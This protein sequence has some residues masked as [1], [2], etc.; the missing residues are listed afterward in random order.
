MA[1]E[2][3]KGFAQT[4]WFRSYFDS[5]AQNG[6]AGAMFWILTPDPQ[7][8]YGVTHVNWQDTAVFAEINRAA[9]LFASLE[10]AKP[11]ARLLDPGQDLVPRQFAFTRVADDPALSPELITR[12][13]RTLLYRFKPEMRSEERR[14]GKECRS[15]WAT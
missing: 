13:G 11:P 1:R 3:Y 9:Q 7:R 14:V 10:N 5:A 8:G 6:I 4:A 2:G 15:E 12:E